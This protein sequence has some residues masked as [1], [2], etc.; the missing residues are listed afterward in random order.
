M[1]PLVTRYLRKEIYTAVIFVM[2]AFLSL[3]AFF[4]LIGEVSKFTKP[5]TN[6]AGIILS[7]FLGMPSRVY[8][9]AP[10]AAL[11]GTIYALA[12]LAANSEFTVLRASGFSTTSA[13]KVI[14]WLGVGIMA[15]TIFFGEV[16]APFSERLSLQVKAN[17]LGQGFDTGFKTGQWIRDTYKDETTNETRFVNIKRLTPDGQI[18]NLEIYQLDAASRLRSIITAQSAEFNED[19]GW[20]L[21][22]VGLYQYP[23]DLV[24]GG[25][26]PS[27][28]ALTSMGWKSSL[29]PDLL[30]GS[31]VQPERMS[32]IQLWRY[33]NFLQE[34]KQ[35][36]E[37]I[38]LALA[39]KLVYP[40]AVL[41]M[42]II[43]L[44][45]AY[46]HVRSGG[47]SIRIFSG[48]ML[49]IGFHMLNNLFSHL[50]MIAKLPPLI[51]ASVPSLLGLS[52]GLFALWWVNR[53]R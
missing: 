16:V 33:Q 29:T 12:Q 36:T 4:D 23:S 26:N 53:V 30:A 42:M 41:V 38:A 37:Q 3:F 32:A 20:L 35:R 25:T 18:L 15:F 5:G 46:L 34:N 7:V 43:A 31:Y 19:N 2:V 14:V 6:V 1:S 21:K 39:K 17:A 44:P 52:G 10:I 48:I 11:I 9:L 40:F 8:E 47:I 28:E 24:K 13:M 45:F 51:S 50:S 27:Y 49:G 22:G